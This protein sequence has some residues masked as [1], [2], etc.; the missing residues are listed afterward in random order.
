[1]SLKVAFY[2]LGCK[3]NYY[4]TEAL[5]GEFRREG[6]TIVD[7]ADKA[8]VYVV[9]TCTVTH[10]AD[11]KSRQL[12]RRAKRRNSQALVAAIGCYVQANP[13]GV[14]SLPEVDLFLGTTE[15]FSLPQLIKGKFAGDDILPQVKPYGEKVVFE[16]RPFL[17]EQGRTRA[18]L[19]IQEGCN[20]FC[21][22]CIIPAARGPLRS[23]PLLQGRKYLREI[24]RA[25]FMEVVLTGIHLGL[26]GVDL[27]P[28]T[29]LASFLQEAAAIEGLARIRLSS[30]EPT[31]FSDELIAVLQAQAKICRHLHI[32]LQSGD[33]TI[34]KKMGRPYD[35]A[36]YTALLRKL[37]DVLPDLAVST[38]VMVGFPGEDA[39]HFRN[40][41]K[42]VRDC[43]FS[44]LHVF[45]F[46]PR[47]GTQAAVMTPQVSPQLKED[48]SR[49]MLSLGEELSTT[50]QQKFLGRK[51]AV[52][53]EKELKMPATQNDTGQQQARGKTGEG[54]RFFEGLTSNYLRVQALVPPGKWRGEIGQVHLTKNCRGYL[55]G[56][57]TR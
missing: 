17:P 22:Y 50:F 47:P 40:S 6:Y 3:V 32:P 14:A 19:K 9:N 27:T 57:L 35:T 4:D 26:Y 51:L 43:S 13:A 55:Q 41:L 53:F 1:M 8:D 28:P 52:L 46:S 54:G 44:R 7:F 11:R 56:V 21:S 20:Q 42:F 24:S 34:L 39:A 45:K 48:R 36:A 16:E 2:T 12:L 30:I 10:L 38:D 5:K 49:E 31:D 25:G 37:R 18:F 15:H 29:N 33:D 23:L